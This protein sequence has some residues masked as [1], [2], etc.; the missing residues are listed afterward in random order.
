M[1]KHEVWKGHLIQ[2]GPP[3][4]F[5]TKISSYCANPEND[6]VLIVDLQRQI[7]EARHERDQLRAQLEEANLIIEAF[8]VSYRKIKS[9]YERE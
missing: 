5:D 6:A 3:R 7:R 9:S 8:L 4:E 1:G 2:P